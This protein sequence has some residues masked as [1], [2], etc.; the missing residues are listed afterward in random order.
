M[1]KRRKLTKDL[2]KVA[3]FAETQGWTVEMG[4]K[5][6]VWKSP[7]GPQVYTSGTSVSASGVRN[8]IS[9]LRRAGLNIPRGHKKVAA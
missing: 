1:K 8:A 5:H 7:D 9:D 4:G 2:E 6:A 3:Q